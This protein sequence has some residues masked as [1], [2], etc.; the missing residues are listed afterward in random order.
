MV[1][2]PDAQAIRVA[3]NWV[4]AH[5]QLPATAQERQRRLGQADLRANY[6]TEAMAALRTRLERR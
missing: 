2:A 5:V 3:T 4:R 1:K 6:L